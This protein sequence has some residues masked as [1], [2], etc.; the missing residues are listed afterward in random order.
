MRE[1]KRA[2][3]RSLRRHYPDQVL[4]VAG[5]LLS[6]ASGPWHLSLTRGTPRNS[7][8]GE[9]GG[10]VGQA[11]LGREGTG[12]FVGGPLVVRTG[13]LKPHQTPA[14][15]KVYY[16]ESHETTS[17]RLVNIPTL[18]SRNITYERATANKLEKTGWR[19]Q[20]GNRE[21]DHSSQTLRLSI[22]GATNT[23]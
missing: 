15:S 21:I 20:N 22:S 3:F 12:G 18:L 14:G 6:N 2:R 5:P 4:R 1:L 7:G 13:P 16:A 9:A 17:P 8:H 19:S 10:G 11:G 23:K